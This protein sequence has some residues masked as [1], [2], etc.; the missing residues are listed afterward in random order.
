MTAFFDCRKQSCGSNANLRENLC[1]E[2]LARLL[3][4]T[5][6]MWSILAADQVEGS[7]TAAIRRGANLTDI[8]RDKTRMRT[9]NS[10][11]ST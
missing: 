2:S 8:R 7:V 10:R 9:E 3:E 11:C 6:T 5:N 4:N 1:G